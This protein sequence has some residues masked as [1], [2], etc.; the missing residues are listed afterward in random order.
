LVTNTLH[1]TTDTCYCVSDAMRG[2]QILRSSHLSFQLRQ[3]FEPLPGILD[4]RSARQP[5][6]KLF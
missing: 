1:L 2:S 6:Q 4:I 5:P 3:I